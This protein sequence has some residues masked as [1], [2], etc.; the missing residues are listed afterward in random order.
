PWIEIAVDNVMTASFPPGPLRILSYIP[1]LRDIPFAAVLFHEV[2]HHLDFTIG[3]PAPSGEAA[4]EAWE[5][6]LLLS[7]TRK[8]FWFLILP[9]R[10]MRVL[11]EGAVHVFRIR[12]KDNSG[13]KRGRRR[14]IF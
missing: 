7:Y 8:H 11:K 13:R 6:R 14:L 1:V 10:A 5:E 9:M 12:T 3:A 2:G 4:A